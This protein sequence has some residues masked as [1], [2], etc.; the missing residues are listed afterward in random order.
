[1]RDN[2]GEKWRYNRKKKKGDK[3]MA[4]ISA[5]V[6]QDD[7]E[8][9]K[10]LTGTL[11]GCEKFKVL[12]YTNDGKM[13]LELILK[14]KPEVVILDLIL[15]SC[16]GFEL[17]EK[18]KEENITCKKVILTS[19]SG[20]DAINRA[21]MLGVDYCMIKPI[22]NEILIE[23]I[24]AVAKEREVSTRLDD[25]ISKIFI[26]VGIPPHIKGYSFLRE[27]VKMV[28]K[29]PEMINS[30][31]KKL[32]PMIGERFSTTPSKV[33]RAIRHAIEVSWAKGRIGTINNIFGVN[34]F[35]GQ[36]KPTNGEFIA[37]IADKMLLE[38]I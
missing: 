8:K 1:M 19:L 14:Y 36:E 13:G 25:K 38:G 27:G 37:L 5:V 34:V 7:I 12:G 17:L 11:N 16:D 15:K 29:N 22:S 24:L 2:F 23:R 21:C 35:L 20:H 18:L 26:S 4:I 28:V 6:L 9:A 30:I 31:T 32:Y 10:E 33:E 3:I